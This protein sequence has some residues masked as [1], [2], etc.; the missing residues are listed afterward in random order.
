MVGNSMLK[1]RIAIAA[2]LGA[3]LLVGCSSDGESSDSSSDSSSTTIESPSGTEAD[4]TTTGD[5]AVT[6]TT[7]EVTLPPP[8]DIEGSVQDV[9]AQTEDLSNISSAIDAWLAD[10][11]GR[12]GVLRNARGVTL[13]LPGNEG[14][15][16]DDVA[17]ALADFDAFS[18][19]LSEHLAVGTMTSD[20]LGDSV[21]TAMGVQYPVG[22][23]P[24][25]GGR[26]IL[27]ADIEATNGVLFVIDG[28]LAPL[29]GS[30][31]G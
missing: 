15:S 6:S 18:I 21:T 30:S 17:A 1:S 19:F 14:F 10:S 16:D 8:V 9:V 20:Q 29:G 24:T 2:L 13:F 23:G 3:W 7:T 27:Q 31:D 26:A 5:D 25:I 11:P 12:E 28:P 4:A 22:E